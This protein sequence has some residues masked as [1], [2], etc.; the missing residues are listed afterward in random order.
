[1]T[2]RERVRAA[3]HFRPVDHAPIDLN[4]TAAAYEKLRSFLGVCRDDRPKPSAAMEVLPH[5]EMLDALGVDCISVKLGGRP[6]MQG[7]LPETMRDAWGVEYRLVR[8]EQGEYYEAA[9]CPLEGATAADLDRYPWPDGQPPEEQVEALVAEVDHLHSATDFA[10]V[11]RFGAPILEVASLLLGMEEWFVRV[12]TDPGFT[13]RLLD[14]IEAI[15]T[16]YNLAGIR[17]AGTKLSIAKVSGDD[18]GTQRSLLYPPDTIRELLLPVL[19]RRWDAVH[20]ELRRVGSDAKVMLHSCGAVRPLIPDLIEAGIEVLDPVQPLAAG[21]SPAE[22]HAEFGG[23]MVFHG[24]ID[25]QELLPHGTPEQVRQTTRDVI[26]E[27]DGLHGGYIAAPSH[28]VQ[29]DTPPENIVAMARAAGVATL[30][31]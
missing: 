9:T 17:A 4:L 15:S 30:R 16:S 12:M 24:G 3:L 7:A 13:R 28:T 2:P 25:L 23:R 31:G 10:L 26:A 11:G 21:M 29:A 27:F 19:K 20:E 14:R 1:V 6:Q 22:L 18:L 5:P 8:Q